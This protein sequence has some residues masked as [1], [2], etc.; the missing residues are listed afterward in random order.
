MARPW[1][2]AAYRPDDSAGTRRQSP[3][4]PTEDDAMTQTPAPRGLSR[5]HLIAA[6]AAAPLA[7]PAIARAQ[8]SIAWT[9]VTAWPKGAPGVGT[10]AEFF[11]RA[12]NAMSGGRL[13]V[14]VYGAGEI[15]PPFEALDAVQQGTAHLLHG[16]PYYWV[17]KSPSLNFFTGVPFG[18]TA[19]EFSAWLRFGG[20][21]ELWRELYAGFDAVPFYVGSSGVQAGGWFTRPVDS[22]DDLKGL[23][24]R[25]AGLGGAVL[26]R[27]GVNAVL[28]PPGEIGP[29]LMSGAIDG[30]DWVGPWNDIAFGL[31]QAARYYYMPGWAEPGPGLEVTIGRR[32]WEAL[33]PDLQAIVE[34]AAAATAETTLAEFNAYNIEAYPK[35]AELGVEVRSFSPEIIDRLR[36]VSREVVAELAEADDLARRIHDSHMDFLDA[37]RAYAP[38]AEGGFLGFRNG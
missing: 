15:V 3:A 10:S 29:A 17:G 35:L 4:V 14:T 7:A 26:S 25:I 24:F 38:M 36:A 2:N 30:T 13:T 19:T 34:H 5:R 1:C 20:G 11:A 22:L 32:A 23:K 37:A 33:A 28:I 21:M 8:D 6:G 9:M 16:T 27:L 12:V 18:M 31:Y